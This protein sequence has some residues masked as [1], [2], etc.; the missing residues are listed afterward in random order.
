RRQRRAPRLQ[1]GER[2]GVPHELDGGAQRRRGE[3]AGLGAARQPGE[4]ALT[5]R[6][7]Q[8]ACEDAVGA[9]AH[10]PWGLDCQH[11]PL[12]A[13]LLVVN[14]D[15]L[16]AAEDDLAVRAGPGIG[17]KASNFRHGR[18]PQKSHLTMVMSVSAITSMVPNHHSLVPLLRSLDPP[19]QP[20]VM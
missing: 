5:L 3:T 4:H 1:L 14:A 20:G 18:L 13:A 12:E 7:V 9:E 10:Q 16:A 8:V 2:A 19:R 17:D 11:A 15:V 6:T